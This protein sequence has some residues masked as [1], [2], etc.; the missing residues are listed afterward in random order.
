MPP[1]NAKKEP[2]VEQPR[3]IVHKT[4]QIEPAFGKN[5]LTAAKAKQLLGW[6]EDPERKT[7]TDD[8]LHQEVSEMF[9]RPVALIHDA[10][11]RPFNTAWC[12]TLKQEILN[13]RWAGPNGTG[14]S[15]NGDAMKVGETGLTLDMQHRAVA[16]ISAVE[17]YN[18]P[19]N[20]H[21]K[22][23]WGKQEPVVDTI[24]VYGVDESDV[25]FK[26]INSGKPATLVDVL[27]RHE[28]L[29]EFKANDRKAVARILDSAIKLLWFRT[30][31]VDSPYSPRRTHAEA[32][33]FWGRH[34]KLIDCV[35][36]IFNEDQGT[37]ISTWIMPG[38]AAGLMYLMGC[39]QSDP[40]AYGDGLAKPRDEGNLVWK[41]WK[42]AKEF[43]VALANPRGPLQK[44]KDAIRVCKDPESG[45]GGNRQE[46]I[47]I[48]I[49]AW[50][51]FKEG[52][53]LTD[54]STGL[55]KSDYFIS[56]EGFWRLTSYPILGGI[57][58]V[59][60]VDESEKESLEDTDEIPEKKEVP[61]TAVVKLNKSS[62]DLLA[63]LIEKHKG[64]VIF[65]EPLT[66]TGAY[67]SFGENASQ[68]AAAL[69]AKAIKQGDGSTVFFL[70]REKVM[71][72]FHDMKKA[73]L[74]LALAVA[75]NGDQNNVKVTPWDG[76]TVL[77]GANE[78]VVA[79]GK[80]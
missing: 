80:K 65:F 63:D 54:K 70:T 52:R 8:Q 64:S 44:M 47:A 46:V 1:R 9:G 58:K 41:D 21:W 30:G 45:A 79:A 39:E 20:S 35:K 43:F 73:G 50:H 59:P 32:L 60:E 24:I 40:D 61:P 2:A 53:A 28:K 3:K 26:T 69:K 6:T 49:R 62:K 18:D 75:V 48:T 76:K 38:P 14:K 5:A 42:K 77:T 74:K 51:Q 27:Y 25:T 78:N 29:M 19:A 16:L 10:R 37:K 15:I 56:G 55:N 17:E 66:P 68:A 4:V 13:K 7:F 36:H 67:Q 22:E 31:A 71:Q 23:V 34:P 33:D 11:N 12:K 72:G 57:D